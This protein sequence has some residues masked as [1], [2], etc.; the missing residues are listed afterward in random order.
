[1]VLPRPQ[2]H[3]HII[4]VSFLLL[5]GHGAMAADDSACLDCHGSRQQI[6]DAAS[7]L[8][9]KIAPDRLAE[10]VV[11]APDRTLPHADVACIDCH[12]KAGEIPHP[13]GMLTGNPCATCHDDAVRQLNH[14]AHRDPQ[15]GTN[16]R[17]P[18]WACHGA[19]DIRPPKDPRSTLSPV[20]VASRCLA[21]HAKR[22]YLAGVHGQGVQLAGLDFAATCVSCH[23][24]HDILAP[25]EAGSRVARRNIS[26]TC[27]K[28]HGRVAEVYRKSVHGAA[29][30]EKDN[31]DVPTCVDCHKAHGTVNPFLPT[32]RLASPQICGR[33]HG[34]AAM[35]TKYGLSTDV[36]TTYVAD[37]HGTTAELFQATS[38][39]QPLNQAVCYDCHGYHDVRS[40]KGVGQQ[41]INRRLLVRCQGC[42]HGAK[43][44]FLSAWTYHY[45]PSPKKYALIYYVRMFY[46]V[47]I[48][49]TIGFFLL[50]IA[51]DAWRRRRGPR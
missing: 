47:A 11:T 29:L 37:F 40:V 24:G 2:N 14:S 41:E 21:C 16:L 46:R 12:P 27:G 35:M 6:E 7:S 9:A 22:D 36:F 5:L 8:E 38:P 45:V 4:L 50:Y 34:D 32:F 20:N 49:S 39:D 1:M 19:H 31:P 28:C 15:G 33:C 48:P 44:P 3:L 42:H 30:T 23:G 18:C 13:A 10:L 26:F 25:A 51:V 17:A 43:F